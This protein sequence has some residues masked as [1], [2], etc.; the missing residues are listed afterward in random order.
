MSKSS[1][2]W[3]AALIVSSACI[4]ACRASIAISLLRCVDV[5]GAVEGRP[6]LPDYTTRKEGI[7]QTVATGPLIRALI[8][9]SSNLEDLGKAKKV[10]HVYYVIFACSSAP[11]D[12][13]LYEGLVYEAKSDGS[14]VGRVDGSIL[15]ENE[16]AV[17][18]PKNLSVIRKRTEGYRGLD[19]TQELE[20]ART[21]GLC[22]MIGGGNS[23]GGGFWSQSLHLP[24]GVG[25]EVLEVVGPAQ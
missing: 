5:D 15:K 7:D 22:L 19:F 9:S 17:Y 6:V 24:I 3:L 2:R 13:D 10:D 18:I 23:W 20:K 4:V 1:R 8:S 16:Y 21:T 25:A 14:G 12:A 11:L